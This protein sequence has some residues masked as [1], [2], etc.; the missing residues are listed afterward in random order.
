MVGC[1]CAMR[2]RRGSRLLV[3]VTHRAQ[4]RL[5][6]C[7]RLVGTSRRFFDFGD[8]ILFQVRRKVRPR[9]RG[10][11]VRQIVFNRILILS[12]PTVAADCS[13][14]ID[15]CVCSRLR[16]KPGQ[17]D[18]GQDA[19]DGYRDHD[20]DEGET[21]SGFQRRLCSAL[22]HVCYSRVLHCS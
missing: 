14:N 1:H 2:S 4:D 22:L 9:S 11:A 16:M 10:I 8:R 20:F 17:G 3:G 7:L 19:D 15:S 5:T 6:C 13:H 21:L 12:P 18:H